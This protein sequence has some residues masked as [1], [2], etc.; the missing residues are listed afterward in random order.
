[1]TTTKIDVISLVK[2]SKGE[3]TR[4]QLEQTET[5]LESA[6][7][8][9]MRNSLNKTGNRVS[10]RKVKKY[11]RSA[12]WKQ[13]VEEATQT[14]LARARAG[15]LD[16]EFDAKANAIMLAASETVGTSAEITPGVDELAKALKG[17][18]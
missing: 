18:E 16:A 7:P 2:D 5:M 13:L 11:L 4:E 1:M 6:N 9:A 17:E 15:E 10:R 12:A 14:V 3:L 8:F